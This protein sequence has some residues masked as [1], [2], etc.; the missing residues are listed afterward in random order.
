M[1][2]PF[3]S[4]KKIENTREA[5][6]FLLYQLHLQGE[7]FSLSEEI[8]KLRLH[9]TFQASSQTL[10][11]FYGTLTHL[12]AVDY[13][14]EQNTSKSLEKI[15][16]FLLAALRLATWQL[17]F[18]KQR[19]EATV[20]EVVKIVKK[21]MHTGAVAFAN[22]VLRNMLLRGFELPN[23]RLDLRYGLPSSL[24]GYVKK[25]ISKEN[26]LAYL[27]KMQEESPLF[28]N[29]CGLEKERSLFEESLER[30]GVLFQRVKNMEIYQNTPFKILE[31]AYVLSLNGKALRYLDSFQK[32]WFYVQGLASMLVSSF[33]TLKAGEHFL[34][35]CAAPGGKSFQVL[36]KYLRFLE[37]QAD[38][39]FN[40][41]TLEPISLYVS[42][43]SASR[44]EKVKENQ[45]RLSFLKD[46]NF[47]SFYEIETL[48]L[49]AQKLPEQEENA[50]KLLG[51]MDV[52]FCDVPCSCLGLLRSKPEVRLHM[53]YEKIQH[54]LL[55]QENILQSAS[56]YLKAGGL[57]I[58]STCT[59]NEQENEAQ[60]QKFLNSEQGQ[61]FQ[62]EDLSLFLPHLTPQTY[63]LQLGFPFYESEGFFLAI[64][65]KI[66]DDCAIMEERKGA[67]P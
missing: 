47:S 39:D 21:Y 51:K 26:L 9:F 12:T 35:L 29:F 44:L 63:A 43:F 25:N 58:Y 22:A 27:E 11:F 54:L 13:F 62:R 6:I 42:D 57:L 50:S 1:K 3:L 59:L 24:L 64:L 28:V 66:S 14:I 56:H 10:A 31:D 34:D 8:E 40:A 67:K 20:D 7:H 33:L 55:L 15:D 23:K 5:C 61:H 30:E 18:G 60:V 37:A 17:A 16:A 48:C 4:K 2:T 32:G 41:L 45:Q 36:K 46:Q 38:R 19:K 65:K 52:V 53:T 49:D